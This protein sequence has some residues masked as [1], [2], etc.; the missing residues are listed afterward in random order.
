MY[1]EDSLFTLTPPQILGVLGIAIG[2]GA[3]FLWL[4]VRMARGPWPL[5]L[6]V[7][8]LAAL[9]FDWLSP[10]VFY[11][12]YRLIL[13]DLP[14]QIVVGPVD[15]MEFSRVIT[16]RDTPSLS[17]HGRGVFY[18]ILVIV[19]VFATRRPRRNAAN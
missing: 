12:Y 5:R 17:T 2:L 10:Q 15:V 11:E 6:L 18:A 7:G 9:A 19:S 14:Q 16:F 3:L 1:S 4:V 13:P 8:L